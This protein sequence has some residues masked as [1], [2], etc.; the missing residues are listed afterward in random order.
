[1]IRLPQPPIPGETIS[2]GISEKDPSAATTKEEPS[3]H[4]N[5]I[6]QSSSADKL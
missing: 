1:M 5:E 6:A 4:T 2:E 3:E